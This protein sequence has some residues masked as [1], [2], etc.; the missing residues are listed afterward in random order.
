MDHI[1][2]DLVNLLVEK[3]ES[4]SLLFSSDKTKSQNI[5]GCPLLYLV[6]S[7]S[8]S[9]TLLS[10]SNAKI[11]DPPYDVSG[12]KKGPTSVMKDK[13]GPFNSTSN[14]KI[15]LAFLLHISSVSDYPLVGRGHFHPLPDRTR[16][17]AKSH[18]PF[19]ST[20]I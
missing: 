4:G 14:K 18:Y 5:L 6:V 13:R 10:G 19:I 9:E 7:R 2:S 8:L 16:F 1:I 15:S 20:F 17:P 3:Q 11:K 12:F